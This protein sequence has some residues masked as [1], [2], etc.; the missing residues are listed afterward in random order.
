M[1]GISASVSKD[2]LEEEFQK[3]GEIEAFRFL[4]D[5]NTAFVEYYKLEDATQAMKNMNGKRI[6]GEQ[7]RVDFLRSSSRRVSRHFHNMYCFI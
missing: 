3:F 5:R 2:Q 6:G 7:M 4:R 1:G